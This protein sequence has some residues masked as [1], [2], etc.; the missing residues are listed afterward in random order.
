MPQFAIYQIIAFFVENRSTGLC[1][2][3]NLI[4][5]HSLNILCKSGSVKWRNCYQCT[6]NVMQL[7]TCTFI[8]RSLST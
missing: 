6:V 4:I 1:K 7:L 5:A 8:Y 3:N 2:I